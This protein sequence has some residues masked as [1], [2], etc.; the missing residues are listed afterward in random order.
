MSLEGGWRSFQHGLFSFSVVSYILMLA[1][2]HLGISIF[3]AGFLKFYPSI[4]LLSVLFWGKGYEVS[5]FPRQRRAC[6]FLNVITWRPTTG[7]KASCPLS[8]KSLRFSFILTS[9]CRRLSS[10]ISKSRFR[11]FAFQILILHDLIPASF[12]FEVDLPQ[13]H[14]FAGGFPNWQWMSNGKNSR[15]MAFLFLFSNF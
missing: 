13:R 5:R 6:R 9:F 10:M 8:M 3:G 11:N 1:S 12:S 14:T 4:Y 7:F 2:F 15:L